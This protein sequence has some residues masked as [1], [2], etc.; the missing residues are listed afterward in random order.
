MSQLTP[1]G[2]CTD[3]DSVMCARVSRGHVSKQRRM[4]TGCDI[5][6]YD[7]YLVLCRR[8][9]FLCDGERQRGTLLG[10]RLDVKGVGEGGCR[11]ERE[12]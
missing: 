6:I 11:S 5:Y 2:V 10:S 7:S 3:L 1:I 12:G 9:N 8:N 4:R